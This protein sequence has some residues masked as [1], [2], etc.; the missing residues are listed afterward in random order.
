MP[1]CHVEFA[2]VE[3]DDYDAVIRWRRGNEAFF[4]PIQLK[5]HV[6]EKLNP[7]ATLRS[8]LEGLSRCFS[9]SDLV[10]VVYLNRRFRLPL[11]P[12]YCPHLKL[13]GVYLIGGVT[14]VR[15]ILIGDLLEESAGISYFDYP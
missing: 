8:L 6:P 4:T 13:G 12:I 11:N 7:D 9:S 15:W 14:K 2:S 10:V 5:E 1:D 3:H